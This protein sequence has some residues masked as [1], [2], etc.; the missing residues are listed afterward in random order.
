MAN[1]NLE[2][3][4]ECE[5]IIQLPKKERECTYCEFP[6]ELVGGYSQRVFDFYR[7]IKSDVP[8]KS[9]CSS[10]YSDFKRE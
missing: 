9:I 8:K 6:N 10:C 1:L 3:R 4:V 2:K 5:I 7:T